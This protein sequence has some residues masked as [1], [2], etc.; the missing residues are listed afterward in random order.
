MSIRVM[1]LP[2]VVGIP[3]AAFL[4]Q[5]FAGL[6][7][8]RR[9]RPPGRLIDVGGHR[10]H[11]DVRGEP[12]D[13][14][15]VLLEAGMVSFSSNWAW[16]QPE[17]ARVTRV[18][19][20]DRAG[21][22]WSD[23]GPKPRDV[24]QSARELHTALERAGVAGPYVLVGHSYGGLAVR[25]FAALYPDEVAGMVLVDASHPDQWAR[26]GVSSKLLGYSNKVASIAARF[27]V[28]RLRKGEYELLARGLPQRQYAE[29]M[30]LASSPRALSTAGDAA[31]AWDDRSRPL[32]DAASS[33]GDLPLV[34]LSVTEQPRMG[35]KLTELQATL[36][37]L[38]S[39]S[40]HITVEGAYH[41]GLLSQQE[42]ARI[43][44]DAILEVV[45]AVERRP[46]A[47]LV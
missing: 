21:L 5:A 27:G 46:P 19:A 33:L 9:F 8:S 29:L 22:G 25:G 31:L 12:T 4:C 47:G 28:F 40:R 43:V 44:S 39:Q 17:V 36:P 38:S 3:A 14:P 24:G 16:V 11:L 41:E 42:H 2:T 30:A 6:R 32:I 34:V 23:P 13:A 26:F 1:L 15:T 35:E 10:L 18:V 7:D 20:V 37:S 45:A